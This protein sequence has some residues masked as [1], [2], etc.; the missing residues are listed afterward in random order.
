MVQG[1]QAGGVLLHHVHRG[2]DRV[3]RERG[4]RRK[5]QCGGRHASIPVLQLVNEAMA[6]GIRFLPVDLRK[7]QSFI[8]QPENGGIR[9]PFSALPGLGEN[10][11]ESIVRAREEE[12]FFSV[13]D[14]QLRAKLSKTV[15]DILRS[16]GA[17]DDVD[18]TDQLTI[19][20]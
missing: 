1:T 19:R 14:L 18:E 12:Q 16:N 20:F 11:A 9:M 7:S 3:R 17:L 4:C 8:F 2:A 5:A 15:I 6:R 10:A 13:E